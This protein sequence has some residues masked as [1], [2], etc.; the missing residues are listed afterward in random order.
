MPDAPMTSADD[1]MRTVELENAK[2]RKINRVL[3]D[4]VERSVDMQ[5]NDFALF[6]TA[7]VLE[8]KVRERTAALERA[9]VELERSNALLRAAKA[10]ADAANRSKTRFLAAAGHDLLQPLNAARLF[11]S[12]LAESKQSAA[13]LRLIESIDA[14]F[15]SFESL[16]RDLLDISRLDAGVLTPEVED[17]SMNLLLGTLAAEFGPLARRQGIDLRVVP[18]RTVVHS[19]KNLLGR[20][21]RNF[22]SNALRYTE[23][24]RVLLGCRR[25]ARGLSIEVH[26]TGPGIPADRLDAIF[27][28][29]RRFDDGRGRGPGYGLGLAIVKRAAR[30]LDHRIEVTSK[31]G[32][33]ARFA[34]IVPY[35]HAG[36]VEERPAPDG[37]MAWKAGLRGACIV[38]LDNEPSVQQG[39]AALLGRWECEV[40]AAQTAD[41]ALVELDRGHLAPDLVIAD[42]HLD[43][44]A[45]GTQAVASLRQRFGHDLPAVIVT[46][47]RSPQVLNEVTELGHQLL[48]KPVRPAKLR[49]LIDHLLA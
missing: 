35:G 48:N 36:R 17:L 6:E 42:Y 23:H 38:V 9:L 19:D 37:A 40:V 16:L 39:M 45:V 14:S 30:I 49:S 41:A 22:L 25:T 18:T 12:A 24:G 34:V 29:F 21:L 8:A 26:D 43:H 31:V 32:I 46:A 15:D 47:D 5:G 11:V 20:I 44:G 13:N 3:M 1:R 7:I 33:G 10:E 2:L 4:R 27:D 28:E